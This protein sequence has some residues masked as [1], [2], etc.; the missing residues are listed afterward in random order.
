MPP[1]EQKRKARRGS[2]RRAYFELFDEESHRDHAALTRCR[3]DSRRF[4]RALGTHPRL[5]ARRHGQNL[6]TLTAPAFVPNLN[7]IMKHA[8]RE[9]LP[10]EREGFGTL[11][12]TRD[13]RLGTVKEVSIGEDRTKVLVIIRVIRAGQ[14]RHERATIRGAEFLWERLGACDGDQQSWSA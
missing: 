12:I 4:L 7:L 6:S 9:I 2:S 5:D 13:A 14:Y 1:I 10:H 8:L 11:G 3:T